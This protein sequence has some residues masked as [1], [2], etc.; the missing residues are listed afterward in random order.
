MEE[1]KPR[2]PDF[3]GDGVAIWKGVDKDGNVMLNVKVL[4]HNIPCFR[5]Q[6]KEEKPKVDVSKLEV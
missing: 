3:K 1:F 4:G 2:S 5:N 6:P